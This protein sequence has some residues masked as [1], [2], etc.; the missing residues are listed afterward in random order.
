LLSSTKQIASKHKNKIEHTK[1]KTQSSVMCKIEKLKSPNP[2]YCRPSLDNHYFQTLPALDYSRTSRDF[3]KPDAKLDQRPE[4]KSD[5]FPQCE[6][7]EPDQ[8]SEEV[9]ANTEKVIQKLYENKKRF[10]DYL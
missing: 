1:K 4:E 10:L 9:Y 7:G 3:N 2:E 5:N 8:N 6:G